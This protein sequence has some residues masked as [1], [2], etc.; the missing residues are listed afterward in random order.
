MTVVG[1]SKPFQYLLKDLWLR[2]HWIYVGCG[3][4]LHDP[5]LSQLR[6][7]GKQWKEESQLTNYFLLQEDKVSEQSTEQSTEQ[8]QPSNIKYVHYAN[9]QQPA[10]ILRKILQNQSIYPFTRIDKNSTLF[11]PPK[12]HAKN[13]PIPSRQE[14]LE[15]TIPA[16]QTDLEVSER[17]NNHGWV[18]VLD[19]ASVGKTTL[20]LRIAVAEENH[21]KSVFYLNLAH[22][23]IDKQELNQALRRLLQKDVLLIID[24]THHNPE[25]AH[26]IWS[27]WQGRQQNSRLL[28]IGTK[29]KKQSYSTPEKSLSYF[30][31]S[32][33]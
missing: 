7:W 17:L 19:V 25:Q 1:Q 10:D 8:D 9:H 24:N 4:G 12:Q 27:A 20:A 5:N 32:S 28:L 33:R 13:M 15:G 23:H 21:N 31:T 6:Q 29:I 26:I 22:G 11:R 14:Y 3:N 2:Y 30:K 16:L 18:Y